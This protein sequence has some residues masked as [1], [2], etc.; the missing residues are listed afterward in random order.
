L[1]VQQRV[2]ERRL[3]RISEAFESEGLLADW[4]RVHLIQTFV[5][6]FQLLH[7]KNLL[8]IILE[9]RLLRDLI[10]EIIIFIR[11]QEVKLEQTRAEILLLCCFLFFLL[12]VLLDI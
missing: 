2:C 4:G 5:F 6:R 8:Q 3:T 1:R 10:Y 11:I 7:F 9:L 12:K